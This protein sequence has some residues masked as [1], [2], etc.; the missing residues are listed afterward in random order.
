[1][2]Q[3]RKIRMTLAAELYKEKLYLHYTV[4][5]IYGGK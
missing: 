5:Y 3:N 2:L 1:M 4:D